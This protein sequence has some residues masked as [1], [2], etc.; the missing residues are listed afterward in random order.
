MR[1]LIRASS[2]FIREC[3]AYS[4]CHF[5]TILS[6]SISATANLLC[7]AVYLDGIC[8]KAQILAVKPFAAGWAKKGKRHKRT[9]AQDCCKNR[10]LEINYVIRFLCCL[11]RIH[12]C[13]SHLTKVS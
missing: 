12:C 6:L 2:A 8:A 9:A 1:V 7:C 13:K 4:E 10:I 3:Y 5:S 11:T